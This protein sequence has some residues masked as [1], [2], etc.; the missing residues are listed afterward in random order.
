MTENRP[1]IP[2]REKEPQSAESPEKETLP[3]NPEADCDRFLLS[4]NTVQIETENFSDDLDAFLH[5]EHHE[6]LEIVTAIRRLDGYISAH[7]HRVLEKLVREHE[8]PDVRLAALRAISDRSYSDVLIFA[9]KDEN[10][11]VRENAVAK[12]A[13]FE[14]DSDGTLFGEQVE[15]I[16]ESENDEGILL[17]ALQ[18]CER[19]SSTSDEFLS[20]THILLQ[21]EELPGSFL[22]TYLD[23]LTDYEISPG[24]AETLWNYSAIRQISEDEREYINPTT[25]LR[26]IL[27]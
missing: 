6:A 27:E 24:F 4:E 18:Y 23:R 15:E 9:S 11:A 19:F 13:D 5:P 21:R 12:M 2:F 7:G 17:T 20:M 14:E 1:D 25:S 26:H 22:F 16:A 10:P 8:D 3:R